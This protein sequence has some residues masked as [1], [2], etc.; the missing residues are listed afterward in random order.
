VGYTENKCMTD[1]DGLPLHMEYM[2]NLVRQGMWEHIEYL[3][4]GDDDYTRHS[5]QRMLANLVEFRTEMLLKY[6]TLQIVEVPVPEVQKKIVQ[7]PEIIMKEY[8]QQQMVEQIVEV[9]V[10]MVQK[11]IVQVPKIVPMIIPEEQKDFEIAATEQGWS[12]DALDTYEEEWFPEVGGQ[13]LKE[14]DGKKFLYT[15]QSP[16]HEADVEDGE[17]GRME[18]TR[19]DNKEV[20]LRGPD[21]QPGDLGY[22]EAEQ[23]D[24]ED[25][26][27]EQTESTMLD[28]V[29]VRLRGPDQQPVNLNFVEG[30]QVP[31]PKVEFAEGEKNT[32]TKGKGRLTADG[33]LHSMRAIVEVP[34]QMVQEMVQEMVE[35]SGEVHHARVWM[36]KKSRTSRRRRTA[37]TA[38]RSG[39]RNS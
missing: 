35:Q 30:V 1:V 4:K 32:S 39:L 16:L 22:A 26:D 31:V 15:M 11:E 8:A 23:K 21:Q 29:E 2:D 12:E 36:R 14:I 38:R 13:Q 19:Q 24:T 18:S 7:V 25:G 34:V 20:R 10:P 37:W 5:L 27:E 9:L 6:D 3:R 17:E 28:T 33:Y